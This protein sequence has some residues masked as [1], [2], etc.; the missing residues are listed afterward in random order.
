MKM[1]KR[2]VK[3]VKEEDTGHHREN[4]FYIDGIFSFQVSTVK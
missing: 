4:V 2:K 1:Y 3:E